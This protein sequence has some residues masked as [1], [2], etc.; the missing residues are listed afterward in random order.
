MPAARLDRPGARDDSVPV[1][2]HLP[3]ITLC[4]SAAATQHGG[5]CGVWLPHTKNV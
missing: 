5:G 2:V 1:R 3:F 4:F